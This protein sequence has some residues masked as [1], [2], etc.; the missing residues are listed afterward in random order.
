MIVRM[1]WRR[2]SRK[3]DRAGQRLVGHSV[4]RNHRK[5]RT[6]SRV[7]LNLLGVTV[8]A[9]LAS[10]ALRGAAWDDRIV[11]WISQAVDVLRGFLTD[12]WMHPR[13]AQAVALLAAT[14]GVSALL[15]FATSL[16]RRA[17]FFI[18]FLV[19]SEVTRRQ[20]R[21]ASYIDLVIG[22]SAPLSL[23]VA[24]AAHG[25]VSLFATLHF[26]LAYAYV[27]LAYDPLRAEQFL[28][29]YILRTRHAWDAPS[30]EELPDEESSEPL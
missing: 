14:T 29:H 26:V 30:E 11:S 28:G 6:W 27:Q 23:G 24:A 18:G 8:L 21:R 13:L 22:L 25:L 10:G 12:D 9:L 3:A 17:P 16:M 20:G 1:N 2:R 7:A 19:M 4:V 15:L 5:S